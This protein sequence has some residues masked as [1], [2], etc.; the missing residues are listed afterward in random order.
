MPNKLQILVAAKF[1]TES[2]PPDNT[3][4][5]ANVL[6]VLFKKSPHSLKFT[7]PISLL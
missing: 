1:E 2:T 3:E 4:I 5:I 6:V 7:T